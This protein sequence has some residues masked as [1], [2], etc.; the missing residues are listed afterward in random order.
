MSSSMKRDT[1]INIRTSS[2]I[3]EE[4]KKF[5]KENNMSLSEY[6]INSSLQGKTI[7]VITEV[8]VK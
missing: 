7:E 6:M 8:K 1:E 3:K 2:E 5:A 4:I